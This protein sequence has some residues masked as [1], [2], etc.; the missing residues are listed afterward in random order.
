MIVSI[1]T[2]WWEL[3]WGSQSG[4]HQTSVSERTDGETGSQ[5]GKPG[6][7]TAVSEP[8]SQE[9][10]PESWENYINPFWQQGLQYSITSHW[11]H[12]IKVLCHLPACHTGDQASDT[13][14]IGGCSHTIPKALLL[15]LPFLLILHLFASHQLVYSSCPSSLP[16]VTSG[17]SL[18][19][20]EWAESST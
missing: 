20:T 10:S 5:T 18:N 1:H 2:A 8:P 7:K 4:G 3:L 19:L 15:R 16:D 6:A 17:S 11:P 12:L 14:I 9:N 13:W